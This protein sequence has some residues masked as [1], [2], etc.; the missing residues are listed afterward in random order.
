MRYLFGLIVVRISRPPS[1]WFSWMGGGYIF[2]NSSQYTLKFTFN[3]Y[4]IMSLFK[5][6]KP[7][8][9]TRVAKVECLNSEKGIF[10]SMHVS[11]DQRDYTVVL[12]LAN[13]TTKTVFHSESLALDEL[14][15]YRSLYKEIK[16]K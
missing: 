7:E 2:C 11:R 10:S 15:R 1:V 9:A 4:N 5:Q 14:R 6:N 3:S 12:C 16:N 8:K 13:K